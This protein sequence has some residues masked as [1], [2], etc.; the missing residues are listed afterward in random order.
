M[1]PFDLPLNS[2]KALQ[3]RL[4]WVGTKHG[5]FDLKSAYRLA[6]ELATPEPFHGN[7]VWDLKILPRF[8]PSYGNVAV[9]ALEI[10]SD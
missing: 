2:K 9:A 3:D 4:T 5:K 8:R 6:V 10:E 7:W 1:L